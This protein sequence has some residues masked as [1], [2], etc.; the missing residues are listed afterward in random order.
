[1]CNLHLTRYWF[2]SL[3]VVHSHCSGIAKLWKEHTLFPVLAKCL[4]WYW[5]LGL[6]T[7]L[8]LVQKLSVWVIL[9]PLA[10]PE[11]CDHSRRQHQ[12]S[13]VQLLSH[14][15]L[16]VTLWINST[17]GLPVHHQ[18]PEFTQTHVHRVS[19][20]I[21]PSHPLSSPSPPAPNPSQHQGLFQWVNSSHEVDQ[22]LEFQLQPQSFQSVPLKSHELKKK[23][24]EFS[25]TKKRK[26]G[27]LKILIF[28][29]LQKEP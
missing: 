21:Q 23:N 2:H 15:G 25:Y 27:Q 16:F 7:C 22:V 26:T 8:L 18:L 17:P 12:F 4:D 9:F 24:N 3:A 19:D 14:V 1:M 6:L 29:I 11:S 13:S 5:V 20:A 10:R 28:I